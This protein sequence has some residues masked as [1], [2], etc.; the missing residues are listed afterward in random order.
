MNGAPVLTIECYLHIPPIFV[1]KELVFL[2]A[3]INLNYYLPFFLETIESRVNEE[4]TRQEDELEILDLKAPPAT[5]ELF[6][7][8]L[9]DDLE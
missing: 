7:L 5:D 6:T 3:L 2:K 9:D 1:S 8:D 4:L